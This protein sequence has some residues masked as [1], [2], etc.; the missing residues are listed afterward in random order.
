MEF[1]G[2]MLAN[3]AEVNRGLLYIQGGGWEFVT[4]SEVP[5]GITAFVAGHI[6]T[7]PDTDADTIAFEAALELPSGE[8]QPIA[9]GMVDL[10][11]THPV[12]GEVKLV[13]VSFHAP[14][15][16]TEGGNHAMLI[17]F[18]ETLVRIP[19]FVRTPMDT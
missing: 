19:V 5:G 11:R 7:E 9:S 14:F 16:V 13:P 4:V 17:A 12:D 10:R 15:K 2:F 3:Y 18:G 1:R 6:V 8:R